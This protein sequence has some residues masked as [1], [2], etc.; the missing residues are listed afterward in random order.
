[1]YQVYKRCN[2]ETSPP[3]LAAPLR[4]DVLSNI[5]GPYTLIMDEGKSVNLMHIHIL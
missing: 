2:M 5:K 4:P 1:M 3:A